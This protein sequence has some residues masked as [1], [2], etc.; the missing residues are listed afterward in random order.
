MNKVVVAGTGMV[1]FRKPGTGDAYDVMARE[2]ARL[3]LADAGI[4]YDAESSRR[5]PASSTA[6]RPPASTRSTRSA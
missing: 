6:T 3:A 4:G 1:P 5:T 2:A